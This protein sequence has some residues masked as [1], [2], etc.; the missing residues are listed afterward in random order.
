VGAHA[1]ACGIEQVWTTGTL[2]RHAAEACGPAAR[3]FDSVAALLAQLPQA[4]A[5]QSVL[6]KGSRFMKMEQ[7]VAALQAADGEAR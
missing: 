4:A 6:V 7:V 2:A 5:F 1:R 3:H